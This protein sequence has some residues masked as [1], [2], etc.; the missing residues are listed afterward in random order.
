VFLAGSG[1]KIAQKR[2]QHPQ[3]TALAHHRKGAQ[4]L[5]MP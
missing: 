1:A 5:E 3:Q 2:P 4:L